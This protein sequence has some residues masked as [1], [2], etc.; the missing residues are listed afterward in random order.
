MGSADL[1]L[2]VCGFYPARHDKPRTYTPRPRYLAIA[3]AVN[4]I[5]GVEHA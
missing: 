2:K 3:A 4:R 5:A 1:F